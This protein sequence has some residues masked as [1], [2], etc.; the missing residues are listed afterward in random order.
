[1][2]F[3]RRVEYVAPLN[4]EVITKDGKKCLQI[5]K[6][7]FDDNKIQELLLHLDQKDVVLFRLEVLNLE[8]VK[9]KLYTHI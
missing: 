7:I 4:L 2:V 9:K 3:A 1:M 8:T 6:I 5:R